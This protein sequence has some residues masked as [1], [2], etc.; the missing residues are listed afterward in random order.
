VA[1]AFEG[2]LKTPIFE[3]ENAFQHSLVQLGVAAE[4]VRLAPYGHVNGA[5][6]VRIF[7][8][9][10]GQLTAR[11][12]GRWLQAFSIGFRRYAQSEG[13]S[14][15]DLVVVDIGTASFWTTLRKINDVVA[16]PGFLLGLYALLTQH[17]GVDEAT[18]RRILAEQR[19]VAMATANLFDKD[20]AC[21]LEISITGTPIGSITSSDIERFRS[22]D[23]SMR[24]REALPDADLD[25]PQA[26]P[27]WRRSLTPRYQ[28]P[29]WDPNLLTGHPRPRPALAEPVYR[30]G[31][32]FGT[33]VNVEG[34][35]YGRF[36][37]MEGV[38]VPLQAPASLLR[39][40]E[41]RRKYRFL[42][43]FIVRHDGMRVAFKAHMAELL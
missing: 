9:T 12:L 30:D 37:G 25:E 43:D 18:L 16:L 23:K 31:W 28:Q 5:L 22:F 39:Q 10:E 26:L 29:E 11:H 6:D 41:T 40:F 3:R 27:T 21:S 17:E 20:N 35:P 19:P 8:E 42:G 34:D 1:T 38:L 32:I 13:Y 33:Y 36:E 4:M 14:G 24:T 15:A 7:F 2:V